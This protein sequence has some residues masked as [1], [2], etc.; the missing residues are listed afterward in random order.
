MNTNAKKP[1]FLKILTF[2]M[3]SLLLLLLLGHGLFG[4]KGY[5]A[6]RSMKQQ[7]EELSHKIE[8]LKRENGQ[9]ME[10]IKALKSDPKAIEKIAREELGLV[11]PGEIKITT[12][13]PESPPKSAPSAPSQES[14]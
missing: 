1:H 10:E 5:L 14:P 7:N 9:T 6:V 4:K 12:G 3:L 11:K 2:V 13:K 8:Q